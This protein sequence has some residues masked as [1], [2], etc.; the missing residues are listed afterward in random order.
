M[1]IITDIKLSD[2]V[3]LIDRKYLF[4]G[5]WR[6]KGSIEEGERALAE[7]KNNISIYGFDPKFV[8]KKFKSKYDNG[9]M[10]VFSDS[11][12]EVAWFDFNDILF[13]KFSK[14]Q[15]VA[16][17]VVI[18]SAT[19]GDGVNKIIDKCHT[20]GD[21][22]DYFYLTGFSAA[23]AEAVTEYGHRHVCEEYGFDYKNTF[24]LSPGYPVWYELRDQL[25]IN[26]LIPLDEIGVVVSETLQLHPEYSTTAMIFIT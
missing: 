24:R 14:S 8:Y 10:S 17:E 25:K 6:L 13:K 2:L 5:L 15:K 4:S 3:S 7:I 18:M 26:K 19:I 1:N 12:K 23:L 20:N 9:L 21:Y 16:D 22:K 11:G